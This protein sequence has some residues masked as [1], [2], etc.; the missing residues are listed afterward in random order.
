MIKR[1]EEKSCAFIARRNDDS[2]LCKI[3]YDDKSDQYYCLPKKAVMQCKGT[4]NKTI[5]CRDGN[6]H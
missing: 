2:K 4:D 5:N 6:N 3:P 1:K